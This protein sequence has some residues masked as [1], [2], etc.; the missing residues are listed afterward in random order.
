M[1]LVDGRDGRYIDVNQPWVALLGLSREELIGRTTPEVNLWPQGEAE[2]QA[3]IRLE[4]RKHL[5]LRGR[6]DGREVRLVRADG[7]AIDCTMSARMVETGGRPV[8]LWLIRD[9]TESRKAQRAL[10]QSEQRLKMIFD[11]AAEAITVHDA[12]G[13]VI[14]C[15]DAA[16]RILDLPRERMLGRVLSDVV[17]G[18]FDEDGLPYDRA[19]LPDVLGMKTGRPSSNMVGAIQHRDGS[20]LWASVNCRPL[21]DEHGRT[22]LVVATFTDITALKET[23][24]ALRLSE[25]RLRRLF[26]HAP[27]PMLYFDTGMRQSQANVAWRRAVGLDPGSLTSEEAF[28]RLG[29]PDAQYRALLR[30]RWNGLVAVAD[31]EDVGPLEADVHCGDGKVRTMAISSGQLDGGFI[32][33]AHDLSERKLVE[34]ELA[35]LNTSLEK[36]VEQRTVELTAAL[37]NLKRTQTELVRSEKL[38]SLGSMVAGIAHELN[39]PIGNAMM[40]ATTLLERHRHFQ[41]QVAIGLRRSVLEDFLATLRE[42]CQVLERNLRRSAELI[43]SF[44]Q[45]AVDQTSHL[46]RRFDLMEV[47]REITMALRPTLRSSAVSLVDE[48]PTGLVM[49]SFP[50]PLGQVLINLVNNAVLHAYPGGSGGKVTIS[51]GPRGEG[52]VWLRVA[53]E[54]RGIPAEHLGKIFDPFFTTRLGQGGSGLGLHITF[55]LVTGVLGGTIGVGSPPGGGAHFD[56]VIP[57]LAP[58]SGPAPAS[59]IGS[60]RGAQVAGG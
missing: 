41:D 29:F 57:R 5:L 4:M 22:S 10:S 14:D 25:G 44:K 37:A 42:A 53:D 58:P 20:L 8:G 45:V 27:V 30:E 50:G 40:V 32:F 52:Q 51:G 56:I 1:A 39:T 9:V 6:I 3:R 55:A 13:L 46:R 60:G 38:S 28:Y 31:G 12:R 18:L 33:S 43:A 35:E 36:R 34:V 59:S 19:R 2:A 49:D 47:V 7:M 24:M 17:A 26:D 11:T 54:G 21:R 16:E 15:N 23:E 48:V